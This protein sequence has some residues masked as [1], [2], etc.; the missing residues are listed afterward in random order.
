F[1]HIDRHG[2]Q[3]AGRAQ[4]GVPVQFHGL[5]KLSALD[6]I[7]KLRKA[8]AVRSAAEVGR[9]SE[10]IDQRGNIEN[11]RIA[12]LIGKPLKEHGDGNELGLHLGGRAPFRSPS[13]HR[14]WKTLPLESK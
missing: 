1:G 5:E 4:Q 8:G 6:G 2:G 3:S 12:L 10:L 14:E 13:Y 7:A 9:I 11:D